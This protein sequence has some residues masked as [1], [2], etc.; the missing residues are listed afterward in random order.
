VIPGRTFMR[1]TIACR[2]QMPLEH[3]GA[4]LGKLRSWHGGHLVRP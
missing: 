2:R 4:V 3:G 1:L